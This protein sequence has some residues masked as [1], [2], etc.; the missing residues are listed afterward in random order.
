[1]S[2]ADVYY[3]YSLRSLVRDIFTGLNAIFSGLALGLPSRR[4]L[5]RNENFITLSL[6]KQLL[7][8]GSLSK[9]VF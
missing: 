1:M 5:V 4:I 6:V 2:F 8:A 3:D 9:F 7:M